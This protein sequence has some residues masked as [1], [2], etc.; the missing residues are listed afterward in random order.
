MVI[1]LLIEFETKQFSLAFFKMRRMRA[2]SLAEA[3]NV[4]GFRTISVS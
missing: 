3:R 1:L 2:S 4:L